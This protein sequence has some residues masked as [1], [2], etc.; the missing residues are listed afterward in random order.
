MNCLTKY[1]Y[2]RD[3]IDADDNMFEKSTMSSFLQ[4]W[5]G[6]DLTGYLLPTDLSTK[7]DS[8]NTLISLL[9]GRYW[10]KPVG[11]TYL[12][13]WEDEIPSET[14]Y[15]VGRSWLRRFLSVLNRTHERYI[16]LLDSYAGAK[17]KMMDDVKSTTSSKRKYNDTPQNA[18]TEGVYEGDNYITDF[19]KFDTENATEFATKMQRLKEL[20]DLYND[21]MDEWVDEFQKTFLEVN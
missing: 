10:E 9:L 11:K 20:D 13:P 6:E 19:T 5:L 8:Y 3:Y 2:L 1:I 21:V 7:A 18:N 16:L 4:F 17:S 14:L 12:P 15:K